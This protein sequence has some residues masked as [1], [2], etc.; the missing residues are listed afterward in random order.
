M[1]ADLYALDVGLVQDL[2]RHY[3]GYKW[4]AH[5]LCL[6]AGFICAFHESVL[7]HLYSVLC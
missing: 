2:R 4:K 1:E 3:L 7:W 6:L 5:C